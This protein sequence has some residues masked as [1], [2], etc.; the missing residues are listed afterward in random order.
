MAA[1]AGAKS[2]R[3]DLRRGLGAGEREAIAL[4]AELSADALLVD[5][6]DARHEADKLGIP[7]LGM[8]RVLADAAARGFGDLAVAFDRLRQTNF[9]ASEYLLRR[10]LDRAAQDRKR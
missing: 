3:Q 10:L 4:A 9:R 7:V 5:D 8:L 6:R 2:G 1:C